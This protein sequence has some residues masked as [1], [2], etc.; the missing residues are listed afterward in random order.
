MVEKYTL[1]KA[2]DGPK[3]CAF[4]A[5]EKG[6]KTGA[7]CK[8]V[9]GDIPAALC[10]TAPTP[11]FNSHIDTSSEDDS[12]AENDTFAKPLVVTP[13]KKKKAAPKEKVSA[14][15][16]AKAKSSAKAKSPAKA[17]TDDDDIFVAPSSKKTKKR[18]SLSADAAPSTPA[19]KKARTAPAAAAHPSPTAPVA[20]A[21]A[22]PAGGGAKLTD[23]LK[24]ME[25]Q[26]G[27]DG[28]GAILGR[29]ASLEESVFGGGYAPSSQVLLARVAALET[30]LLGVVP[31][32]AA[33]APM[34]TAAD[35]R[36]S[37]M[38][39]KER[40]E[41]T[42][43]KSVQI[44][45]TPEK[46]LFDKSKP[47]GKLH[48]KSPKK[49]SDQT[50]VP[51]FRSLAASL[52]VAAFSLPYEGKPE[53]EATTETDGSPGEESEAEAEAEEEGPPLA[54]L[55]D[56]STPEGILWAPIVRRTRAHRS[57]GS[58]FCKP[59]P[60]HNGKPNLRAKPYGKWCEGNPHVI[61]IDCEMCLARD[62]KILDHNALCRISVVNGVNPEEVLL[63]TLVNPDGK[64]L[65]YRTWINGI[66]D[67][68]MRGVAFTLD[69]ARDFMMSLMSDQTVV[70]GHS[71]KGDLASLGIMHGVVADSALL[72]SIKDNPRQTPSLGDLSARV[73]DKAM[74]DT[75]DSV[76]DAR[77]A[78]LAL[79][80][81]LGKDLNAV[82]WEVERVP[83]LI[84]KKRNAQREYFRQMGR[85]R[86]GG[87]GASRGR[88]V[89]RSGRDSSRG[90][91]ASRSIDDDDACCLLVHRIPKRCTQEH[92]SKM[93]AAHV[94]DVPAKIPPIE[95]GRGNT[96]KVMVKFESKEQAASVF[97]GIEG[98]I[99][100]DAG[101]TSQKRV[102]LKHGGYINIRGI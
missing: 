91:S 26:V 47:P 10:P 75:H 24:E 9:H 38:K 100:D 34:T 61:A 80:K 52:P 39:K 51:S 102:Y 76:N 16:P 7:S 67:K 79:Q 88:S 78:L 83:G 99:N 25:E 55:P 30:N 60:L 48:E 14:K 28:S 71:V 87:G 41:P 49:I 53:G 92:L 4:Y 3:V 31:A 57:F 74:P 63:D 89:E 72:Y 13:A 94:G 64:V 2:G 22:S 85:E 15:S 43:K 101:G 1:H 19:T 77:T 50:A 54:P 44:S 68:N 42:E 81:V 69:H 62:G 27:L 29:V 40:K 5:T 82:D 96:G 46:K 70:V 73:L 59:H 37:A 11:A 18:S 97:E 35:V 12:A 98:K 8:F 23:R 84:E 20:A 21:G 93:F 33:D 86:K 6:C 95:F 65:D 56:F 45:S 32:T 66:A 17:V 36:S 90:R 58:S